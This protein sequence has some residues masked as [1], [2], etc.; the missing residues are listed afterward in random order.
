MAIRKTITLTA[1]QDAR[2]LEELRAAL[3]ERL[4]SGTSGRAMPEIWKEAVRR[5]ARFDRGEGVEMT[6][7]E[8]E[9]AVAERCHDDDEG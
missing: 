6:P 7:E 4:D 2:K 1:Q 8:L 5:F 9:E 3:E